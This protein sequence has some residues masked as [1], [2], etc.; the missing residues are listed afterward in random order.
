MQTAARASA[1]DARAPYGKLQAPWSSARHTHPQAPDG[2]RA[3]MAWPF[4][5]LESV[6]WA[7]WSAAPRLSWPPFLQGCYGLNVSPKFMC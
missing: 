3:R 1:G 2:D 6:S 5:P 7:A 4:L